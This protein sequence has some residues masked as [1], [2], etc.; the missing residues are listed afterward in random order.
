MSE[1]KFFM[2]D[3]F[4]IQIPDGLLTQYGTSVKTTLL[5]SSEE[6]EQVKKVLIDGKRKALVYL[7]RTKEPFKRVNRGVDINNID[8]SLYKAEHCKPK[9]L[10]PLE[11]HTAEAESILYCLEHSA[12]RKS[13]VTQ[14]LIDMLNAS[15]E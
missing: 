4:T 12:K 15:L 3:Q 2:E 1:D 6:I 5:L 9:Q 7:E 8:M 10:Y 13:K 11:L 14:Q